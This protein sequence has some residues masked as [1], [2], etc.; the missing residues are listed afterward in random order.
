MR[1]CALARVAQQID[2]NSES[3]FLAEIQKISS[4]TGTVD[5]IDITLDKLPAHP[6]L[7]TKQDYDRAYL[8]ELF[9]RAGYTDVTDNELAAF[10]SAVN[11]FTGAPFALAADL[12]TLRE[13]QLQNGKIKTSTSEWR[14]AVVAAGMREIYR[15]RQEWSE[16]LEAAR[17]KSQTYGEDALK[18]WAALHVNA[19]VNLINGLTEPLRALAV[20]GPGVEIP[21]LPR[22]QAVDRSEFWQAQGRGQVA[23][24][25]GT[26]T[27]GVLGGGP[28]L[29]ATTPGK[30]IA[31]T[32]A[33]YNIGAGAAGV[34]VTQKNN[35]G[36]ARSMSP[37]ERTIRITGGVVTAFGVSQQLGGT[38]ATGAGSTAIQETEAVATNG[39]RMRIAVSEEQ[40]THEAHIA[41]MRRMDKPLTEKPTALP[42][43]EANERITHGEWYARKE[44]REAI[45]ESEQTIH[46]YK[47]IK[48][49]SIEDAKR[50][51]V[52]EAQYLPSTNVKVIEKD[53]MLAA[54]KNGYLLKRDGGTYYFF[55]RFD[56]VIGYDGG[57]ATNWVRVELTSGKV[58]HGHPMS[59]ERVRGY[60][61]SIKE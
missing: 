54:M 17:L 56:E 13:I 15:Q 46:A 47:H 20:L 21:A 51:S 30:I 52:R 45:A 33:A 12:N 43:V 4:K 40:T 27:V 19:P 10:Q 37:L 14:Q 34:D 23:E 6:E 31:A 41:Q 61:P 39:W 48:A 28:A 11:R 44:L 9:R 53:A 25:A 5:N 38:F 57:R 32:D 18:G 16:A 36:Q 50:F 26:I 3:P 1:A 8:R 55:H 58:Y 2:Q 42:K 22:W 24:I 35:R 60:I 49:K 7:A 59:I 29:V